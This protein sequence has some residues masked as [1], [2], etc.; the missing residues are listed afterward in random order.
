LI[1]QSVLKNKKIIESGKVL[2]IELQ[3]SINSLCSEP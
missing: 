2:N 3:P 1:E